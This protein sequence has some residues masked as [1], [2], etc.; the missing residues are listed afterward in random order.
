MKISVIG[1]GAYGIALALQLA[2]KGDNKYGKNIKRPWKQEIKTKSISMTKIKLTKSLI[3]WNT[4][5]LANS[6]NATKTKS[7]DERPQD[8]K[9]KEAERFSKDIF[10]K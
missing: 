1:T 4:L 9:I 8:N 10:E 6:I 7:I 3:Y 5:D 2:K